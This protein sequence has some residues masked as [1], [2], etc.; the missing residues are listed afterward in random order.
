M[1]ELVYEGFEQT[2]YEELEALFVEWRKQLACEWQVDLE[3]INTIFVEDGFYP[4]YYNQNPRILFMG[5]EG[6]GLADCYTYT[7]CLFQWYKEGILDGKKLENSQFH[8]LICYLTY[9]FKMYW[10]NGTFPRWNDIPWASEIG[11]GIGT[12]NGCSFAFMNLSKISNDSK[13]FNTDYATMS[14]FL[15][16]SK[17]GDFIAREIDILDP[18]LIVTMNFSPYF[19]S[20]GIEVV[21]DENHTIEF[22]ANHDVCFQFAKIGG[23]IRPLLD[24]WHFSAWTKDM[25]SNYYN[26]LMS[27]A[28]RIDMRRLC[29]SAEIGSV[30][31]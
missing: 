27:I 3:K 29:E 31:K 28:E 12:H 16:A 8:S 2:K 9:A 4:G 10:A 19:S 25:N 7:G 1:S 20:A 22:D 18:T 13:Q 17:K 14:R 15:D 23:K 21:T 11:S 26:P 30:R 6:R 5:R 24:M